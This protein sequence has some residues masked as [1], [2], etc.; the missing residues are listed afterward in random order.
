MLMKAGSP[1]SCPD[2]R[3]LWDSLMHLLE[4]KSL[5]GVNFVR[6]NTII[7][8]QMTPTGTCSIV[9]EGG[10]I[11]PSSEKPSEIARRVEDAMAAK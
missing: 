9:L 10:A 5:G 7:A 1:P 6:A 3:G 8:L 2:A 11:I 4:V